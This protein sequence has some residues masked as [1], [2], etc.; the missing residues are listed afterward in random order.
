MSEQTLTEFIQALKA[1]HA[2]TTNLERS[3]QITGRILL[4]TEQLTDFM[5]DPRLS[6]FEELHEE[7]Y[8]EYWDS[9]KLL[10]IMWGTLEEIAKQLP[11]IRVKAVP[12]S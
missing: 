4:E 10:D 5:P 7:V 1:A 11:G 9:T 12:S 6:L 2:Y 3:V 8:R